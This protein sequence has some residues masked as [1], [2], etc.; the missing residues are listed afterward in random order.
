MNDLY[1][2]GSLMYLSGG[3]KAMIEGAHYKGPLARFTVLDLTRVR[4]GP[5][6]ARQFA[7]WGANVIKI[8]PPEKSDSSVGLGGERHSA[9]F[10]NT[11]RNKRGIT[12]DL[13]NP[14]GR[15]LFLKMVKQV[16]VVIENF[17]P[18]VKNRL[19]IDY[20]TLS[21]K[22]PGIVLASLSGFGQEGAYADLPAFDQIIQ[23]MSGL[24]SVTGLPGQGPVRAGIPIADLSTGLFGAIGIFIALL[25]REVTGRGRWVQ[26]SLIQSM[27]AMMDL[28]AAGYL[29][30]DVSPVSAGNHHPTGIPTGLFKTKDG[31]LNIAADGE[32][33][34]RRFCAAL[35][36][37]EL[38][39]KSGY[40]TV[41]QRSENRDAVNADIERL[42][43][44]KTSA[45]WREILQEAEIPFGHVYDMA[46]VFSDTAIEQLG[47]SK[48]LNHPMLGT[49]SVLSH[50]VHLAEH[51]D[52]TPS[53][54]PER[55]EHTDEV[56]KEFGFDMP[57]IDHLKSL[58]A[59]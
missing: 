48:R 39:E 58:G 12:I 16:D 5:T 28:Q 52:T 24:M 14:A 54:S 33:M 40:Q 31:D 23:G 19:G 17:R 4:S 38:A 51:R 32:K 21:K 53:P 35:G 22:N 1:R 10:Q 42:L 34:W 44:N 8:E 29:R 41:S 56:L 47:V 20:E 6:A 18:K 26:T 3:K 49:F 50:P 36:E 15:D 7:D 9:D 13:K 57:E 37:P 11:H 46:E 27:I 59:I 30:T 43:A 55:G 45:E 25:E 2:N